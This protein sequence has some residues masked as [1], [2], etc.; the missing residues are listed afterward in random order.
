M[1]TAPPPP[2]DLDLAR[3]GI[4]ALYEPFKAA[5]LSLVVNFLGRRARLGYD[6]S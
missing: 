2:R 5:E 6:P 4:V 1:P 3:L